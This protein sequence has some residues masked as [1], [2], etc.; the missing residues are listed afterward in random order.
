MEHTKSERDHKAWTTAEVKLLMEGKDVPGRTKKAMSIMRSK[1]GAATKRRPWT[2]AEDQLILKGIKPEGR[3][4]SAIMNRKH[5]LGYH[6][7]LAEPNGQVEI[8]FNTPAQPVKRHVAPKHAAA[9]KIL[10]LVNALYKGG[11]TPKEIAQS[12]NISIEAVKASITL[13]KKI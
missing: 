7:K 5:Q 1:I 4:D 6:G 13:L 9:H 11:Y 8:N 2:P 10:R 12:Q 3:S